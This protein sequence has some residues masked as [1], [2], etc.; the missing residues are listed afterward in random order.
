MKRFLIAL[1]ILAM[2][3]LPAGATWDSDSVRTK[4]WG[5]SEVLTEPD[6]EGQFDVIHTYIN[7]MMDATSGH[8]H[9]GTANEGVLIDLDD[10]AGVIGVKGV[11]DVDKGGTGL[12]TLTDGGILLG[13]GTGDVTPM[14]VL[15]DGS[16]VIGDGT[17]DP[18]PLAAFTSSTGQLKHENGGI[19]T[20]IS[21]IVKGGL[22]VG[23]GTGTMGILT[24][25]GTNGYALIADSSEPNGIA[26]QQLNTLVWSW[27]GARTGRI[28]HGT[29][30]TPANADGNVGNQIA[31]VEG[32]TSYTAMLRGKFLK[33]PSINTVTVYANSWHNNVVQGDIQVDI[34]GQTGTA[35]VDSSTITNEITSFTIDVSSLTDGQMH[36]I[37]VNGKN[38]SGGTA[39]RLYI[40]WINM[41]GS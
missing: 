5:A 12:A 4:N 28:D 6:L 19:E 24:V 41:Y 39:S 26:W 35:A 34:G 36:D 30:T 32:Q 2:T 1:L 33:Q 27:V 18:V 31:F 16:I 8:K 20:D 21:A 38:D 10:D 40:A 7:D 25:T 15:A 11:L 14:A 13:S 23:S 22:L 3:A 9:D 17:T 37:T 29:S